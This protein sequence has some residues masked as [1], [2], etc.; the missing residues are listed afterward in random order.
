MNERIAQTQLSIETA[1]MKEDKET[2]KDC[3][4]KRVKIESKVATK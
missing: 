3:M 1:R 2:E 4:Q